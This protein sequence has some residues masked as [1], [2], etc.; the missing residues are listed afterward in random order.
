MSADQQ[1]YV[2]TFTYKTIGDLD[3]QADVLRGS[4]EASQ[5]VVVW[6][7]GGGLIG[8]SRSWID[9][10][11]AELLLGAGYAIVSI[12]Y[13]L[14]PETKLPELIADVEDGL[15]WVRNELPKLLPVDSRR[16]AV[17][18]SSAGGYLSLV[19][20]YRV[21]PPP[22]VLV[23]FWGYGDIIGDWYSQPSRAARHWQ[24]VV[25]REEAYRQVSGQPIS[26]DRDRK[27]NGSIFY[28]YCRQHGE[29]PSAVSGWDPH[30]EPERFFP[31]MPVRHVTATYPPT[32]LI[33]GTDDTDV[34]YVQS[35]MMAAELSKNNV[36]HEL[37]TIEGGEHGPGRDNKERF[38]AAYQRALT[39]VNRHM[40]R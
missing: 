12:D 7:H 14:A 36:E 38:D 33:H 18:G 31:F 23:S 37:I 1:S 13:R 15:A 34:P 35:V 19:T 27:G 22:D 6:I 24:E 40:D 16:I 11:I 20:G 17:M 25:S 28:Q 10:R 2:S 9:G 26:A 21:Q 30:Q 4:V 5:P 3:V 29:W 8:G 32:L 39:F